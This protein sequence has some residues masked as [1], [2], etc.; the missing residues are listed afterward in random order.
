VFSSQQ[1]R[2][3]RTA[4][5][6]GWAR[7]QVCSHHH[8]HPARP[9]PWNCRTGAYFSPQRANRSDSPLISGCDLLIRG[10]TLLISEPAHASIRYRVRPLQ[11]GNDIAGI[12]NTHRL[13]RCWRQK[14]DEM[15]DATRV[16]AEN[17]RK[18][19]PREN[20]QR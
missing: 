13:P 12:R 18:G 7:V 17:A 19:A 8:C 11:A 14:A 10:A 9:H 3:V 5:G 4:E 2:R 20:K 15:Q 1:Q 6:R 16:F